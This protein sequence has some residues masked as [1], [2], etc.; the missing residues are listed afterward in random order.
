[1]PSH[2]LRTERLRLLPLDAVEMRLFVEEWPALQRRLGAK[3]SPAWM[4]DPRTLGAAL[5]QREQMLRDPG[6][7]LWWTFWQV[8]LASE[9]VTIGLVDFKGPPGPEG[10]ITIGFSFARAHWDHGYA[11]EAVSALVAWALQQPGVRFIEADT[12]VTNV[13]SQRVL[14]KL[15]FVSTGPVAEGVARHGGTGDLLAW[16]LVKRGGSTRSR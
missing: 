7:W 5:R 14:E 3:P 9:G 12:E 11:T 2:E 8:V 13:R 6:A 1:V 10:R 16:R 4:G 15:G